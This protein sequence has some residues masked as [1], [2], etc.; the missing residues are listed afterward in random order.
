MLCEFYLNFKKVSERDSYPSNLQE[1]RTL[2]KQWDEHWGRCI[3]GE[4]QSL[5]FPTMVTQFG[6]H[7]LAWGSGA[8]LAKYVN[9]SKHPFSLKILHTSTYWV[10]MKYTSPLFLLRIIEADDQWQW[11]ST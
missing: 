1:K 10:T 6:R 9:S 5:N 7:V 2:E 3:W 4:A 11:F 8:Q